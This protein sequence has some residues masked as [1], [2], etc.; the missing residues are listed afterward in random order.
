MDSQLPSR[1]LVISDTHGVNLASGHRESVDLIIHCG[2]F[3]QESNLD[4]FK[5]AI[6]LLK[7][8]VAPL[9]LVIAGNHDFTLDT[10]VFAQKLI[11]ANL[12]P[13]HK[14]KAVKQAYGDFGEAR[15]LLDA[16]RD[17]GIIFLDEGT[18]EIKLSNGALLRIYASPYIPSK[19]GSWGFCYDPTEGHDWKIGKDIDIV[20]TH[21]PPKGILD[22]KHNKQRVGCSDLF[23]AIA[24]ARP[25]MHCF[26]HIH[27]AWGAKKVTWQD[28]EC[29]DLPSHFTDMDNDNSEL[30]E[31][32]VTLRPGKFDSPAGKKLKEEKLRKLVQTG[33]CY[34]APT[35]QRG[36]HTLFVNAAIEG[37]ET[38]TQQ[39]PWLVELDLSRNQEN[40]NN[41]NA[42]ETTETTM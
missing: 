28:T 32:L 23:G 16:Q 38:E 8:L 31:S 20:I 2:D 1:I 10:P 27:E 19:A 22:Y 11:E 35:L 5:Q 40:D 41:M 42:S 6:S 25:L 15:S 12:Q 4:E 18:H 29:S 34:T 21:G 13:P 17:A 36:M 24:K 3:T 37:A 14:D 9:R 33:Y 30:I 7:S 26:G 39:S